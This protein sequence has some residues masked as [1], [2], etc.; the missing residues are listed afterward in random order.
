MTCRCVSHEGFMRPV[1]YALQSS[2]RPVLI[3]STLNATASEDIAREMEARSPGRFRGQKRASHIVFSLGDNERFS[4]EQWKEF[5]RHF[6]ERFGYDHGILVTHGDT[7]HDHAHFIGDRCRLNGQTVP[8]SFERIRLRKFCMEMEQH[9][10]LTRTPARS[11]KSRVNKDELELAARLHREGK[12]PTPVPERMAVAAAVKAALG[13]CPTLAA[14]D[15][16]LRRQKIET[17]WRHDDQGRPVGVSFCR[18]EAAI[19][20]RHAGVSCQ[21]LTLHYG[22][23]GTTTHEQSHRITIPGGIA[24]MDGTV[25]RPHRGFTEGRHAGEHAGTGCTAITDARSCGGSD[26]VLG[27]VEE[28]IREIGSLV[29]QALA[30][31][32]VLCREEVKNGERFSNELQRRAV[33]HKKI[34][35]KSKQHNR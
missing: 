9:F 16:Q 26:S 22:E 28:P 15:A 29:C 30:G 32:A 2:K 6:R 10:G 21:T 33:R 20:G 13:Q 25:G 27:I 23:K 17:R 31:M 18:G 4:Y 24:A 1:V 12:R 7:R 14:F 34:Y 19:S 11:L 8:T 35:S 3:H 5:D